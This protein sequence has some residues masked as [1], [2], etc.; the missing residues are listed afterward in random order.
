MP[1]GRSSPRHESL[2]FSNKKNQDNLKY[3]DENNNPNAYMS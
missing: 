1:Y 2:D 3:I